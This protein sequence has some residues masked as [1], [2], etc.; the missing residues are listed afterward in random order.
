MKPGVRLVWTASGLEMAGLLMTGSWFYWN[1]GIAKGSNI[2]GAI[3][4]L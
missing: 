1:F 2:G 3:R 4:E